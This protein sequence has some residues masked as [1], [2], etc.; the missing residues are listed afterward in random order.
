MEKFF[1]FST[2]KLDKNMNHIM[3]TS[4]YQDTKALNQLNTLIQDGKEMA[5]VHALYLSQLCQSTS[6][7]ILALHGFYTITCHPKNI[8]HILQNR[9]DNYP[10][11]P[12]WQAAF[13]D[14]LGQGIL[15]SDGESWLIQ[16]K[17]AA[18]GFT[19]RILR[20]AMVRW[21]NRTIKNHL[22][23]ILDKA[24]NEKKLVDFED[25]GYGR[26]VTASEDQVQSDTLKNS[27][28][29][30]DSRSSKR[31][32][33]RASM[34]SFIQFSMIRRLLLIFSQ[35]LSPKSSSMSI[36][37]Q[38]AVS[39]VVATGLSSNSTESV[40]GHGLPLAQTNKHFLQR[41]CK[42][43]WQIFTGLAKVIYIYICIYVKH[44][45]I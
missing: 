19:T 20:Q 21:V 34:A 37:N 31:A 1:K 12:H 4:A 8:E 27:A 35:F 32:S 33:F 29:E 18:L 36:V 45:G 23:C 10:R 40:C 6:L 17:I 14:L 2:M 39:K 15:T 25:L 16:R 43:Y 30:K 9:F 5:S 13:H 42:T 11:G 44:I 3:I 26:G 22:W 38:V 7:S 28:C 24:S 41:K